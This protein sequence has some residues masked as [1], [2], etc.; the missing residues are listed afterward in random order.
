MSPL[1][2]LRGRDT[3]KIVSN[4]GRLTVVERKVSKMNVSG[5]TSTDV[6]STD[7]QVR[8]VTEEEAAFFYEHGWVKLSGLISEEDAGR[9]QAE[10]DQLATSSSS[11]LE[12][13]ATEAGLGTRAVQLPQFQPINFPSRRSELFSSLAF[14][15]QLGQNAERLMS[16]PVI[17]PRKAFKSY[18]G[19]LIK[20]PAESGAEGTRWHQDEPT[21]PIDRGGSLTFWVALVPVS[22]EMGSLR[23]VDRSHR[24]GSLGRFQH[25]A[26]GD[27][28]K[29]YPGIAEQMDL[30]DGNDLKPGD[31]TVHDSYMVHAAGPN[32]TDR[33][34]WAC[35]QA[36]MPA[37]ALYT[38][39][40]HVGFGSY[41]FTVNEPIVHPDFPITAD[42]QKAPWA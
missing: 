7:V 8:S 30:L 13:K 5:A 22:A 11:D 19:M 16:N 3:F 6:T 1:T 42:G 27:T 4:Y 29:N 2:A 36:F 12:L 31:A 9:L 41:G 15:Q 34:R 24:L 21:A 17:G 26:D 33:P 23:F 39:A 10:A 25:T 18:D 28:V 14:S 40:H 35:V 32:R 38:G 20:M 37:D